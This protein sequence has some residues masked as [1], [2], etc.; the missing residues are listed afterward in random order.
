MRSE[1]ALARLL[2]ELEWR[3]VVLPALLTALPLPTGVAE[4]VLGPS[5]GLKKSSS[6]ESLQ[7]AI[8][9]V[10][11]NS[12]INVKRARSRIARGRG[13]NES[14]RAAI[15]KSYEKPVARAPQ[16]DNSTEICECLHIRCSCRGFSFY[17][18]HTSRRSLQRNKTTGI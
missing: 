4:Q 13:C 7:T 9:E 10:T 8:A 3:A 12:E 11:L 15:D 5:L 16:D 18:M 1:T 17:I 2:G 14:F 6:L